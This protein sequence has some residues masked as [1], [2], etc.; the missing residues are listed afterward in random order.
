[1]S[2]IGKK[3]RK[4]P[5]AGSGSYGVTL[6]LAEEEEQGEKGEEGRRELKRKRRQTDTYVIHAVQS[7][8]VSH[9]CLTTLCAD[10][11]VLKKSEHL[12]RSRSLPQSHQ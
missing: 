9:S 11:A 3:N 4:K 1:M 8:T 10:S 7:C 12:W 2:N 6:L 5:S